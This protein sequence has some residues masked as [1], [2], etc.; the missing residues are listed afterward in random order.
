M[1]LSRI[2]L[3]TSKRRTQLALAYPN[4]FHGVVEEAFLEKQKRN[5]WRIDTLRDKTYLLIL[6]V[7]IPD[8]SKIVEQF[9]Y[10]SIN[11][12]TKKYGQLL[13]RIQKDSVWH[14]RLVANPTHSIKNK[15]KRGKVVAYVSDKEQLKWLNNQAE[16]KGFMVI[17]DSVGVM[18]SNWKIFHKHGRKQKV[19]ILEVIFEGRLKVEDVDTFKNTLLNG[20]GREKAYGM[21]LL[22]IAGME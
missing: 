7:S 5:L 19:S 21:G 2:L 13:D 22:T 8:L 15:D 18:G 14:F 1:Y 10:P 3:D 9:G 17:P 16:K 11:G 6:S 4:K 20:I 12:E